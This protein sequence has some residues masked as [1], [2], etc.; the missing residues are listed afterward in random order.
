VTQSKRLTKKDTCT[1][2]R[3]PTYETKFCSKKNIWN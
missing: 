3:R 2:W 1:S